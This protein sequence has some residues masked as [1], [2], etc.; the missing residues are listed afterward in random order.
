MKISKITICNYRSVKFEVI[1][2][3]EFNIFVGQNNHGKT[4]IFES[5]EWFFNGPRRGEEIDDVR[6]C[7]AGKEEVYVEV[8]FIGVKSGLDGM[9]NEGNKTKL[10]NLL[11]ELDQ[12][13]IRRSCLDPKNRIFILEGKIIEKLPTGFDNALNDFLPKFEY[14]DTKKFYEDLAKYGKTT[15]IGTML[16]GVL[17]TLLEENNEYRQFKEKF[18][19]LFGSEKSQVKAEL[20]NLS[21]KVKIYL[22]KQFP[23][24]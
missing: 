20:D 12:V 6:H 9:H 19:E 11:G 8:E 7:K 4:N 5:L 22:E 21:G 18:D 2:P 13:T 16:S 17:E 14:V 3:S 23:D 15:P 10:S 1:N 24:N